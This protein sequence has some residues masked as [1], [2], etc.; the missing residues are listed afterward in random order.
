MISRKSLVAI[1]A[2][3]L[4]MPAAAFASGGWMIGARGGVGIPMGDL[5]DGY[6]SGLLIALDASHMMSP[7]LAIGVDGNYI[8]N[9][10][11]DA[12]AASLPATSDAELKFMHYG[13]HAKYMMGSSN[14]KMM[15]Y[16][17]GGA[18]LYNI[19]FEVTD[20]N[21]ALE[22]KSSD[23]KFGVRGGVGVNMMVGQSWGIGVQADYNDVFT[24]G[25]S[26]QFVGL[27]AGLHFMLSPSSS[28]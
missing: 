24:D 25:G 6:K 9:N 23:T 13:A 7:K 15:P 27:S 18:G 19:K 5:K 10:P 2:V 28:Q 1:T 3:L 14:S 11:S 17:V 26:S 20:P 16:L 21:P 4:L 12:Y 22:A 8:K